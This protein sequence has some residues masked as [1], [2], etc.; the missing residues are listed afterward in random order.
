V[1]F[2]PNL[3]SWSAK[4]QATVSRFSTEAEYNSVANA[5]A[6]VIWMQ[7]LLAELR[8]QLKKHHIY[9]V[10]I[11]VQ[12]ICQQIQSFMHEPNI[13]RLNFTLS[14]NEYIAQATGD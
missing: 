13:L 11:W 7:S 5:T 3:I 1:F 14:E 2:G 8:V 6:E 4:K 10:I 12:H 9:C